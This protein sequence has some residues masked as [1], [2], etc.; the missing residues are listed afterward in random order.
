MPFK[1]E[2]KQTILTPQGYEK[3]KSELSFLK[4]VQLKNVLDKL[5]AAL[6]S[7]RALLGN[8]AYEQAFN[9]KELVEIKIDELSRLLAQASV[10]FDPG[11]RHQAGIGSTVSLQIEADVEVYTLVNS[12]EVEPGKVSHESPLGKSLLGKPVGS[13]VVVEVPAGRL[14]YKILKIS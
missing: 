10:S 8:T 14:I 12:W 3:V 2:L 1:K 9:E 6:E 7:E 11:N 4:E 5:S 13:E